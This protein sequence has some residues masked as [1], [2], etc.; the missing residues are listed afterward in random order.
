MSNVTHDSPE[1]EM[2]SRRMEQIRRSLDEDVQDIVEVARDMA[3]WRYYVRAYPW[4]FLGAAF[5]GGYILVP[6]KAARRRPVVVDDS[7]LV[8]T[9]RADGTPKLPSNS[10]MRGVRGAL[11][12]FVSS[13]VMRSVLSHATRQI[14]KLL[15][16]P[17]MG[18]PAEEVPHE[19]WQGV[20]R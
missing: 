13:L 4:F 3:K 20:R 15:A 2:I 5:A 9:D 11:L 10:G 1:I 6:R 17:P 7:K 16:P 8:I 19:R 14:D 18:S 12:T